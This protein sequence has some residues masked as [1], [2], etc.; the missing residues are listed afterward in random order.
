MQV[1]TFLSFSVPVSGTALD[2]MLRLIGVAAIIVAFFKGIKSLTTNPA[3]PVTQKNP[4]A[5]P[6]S[7]PPTQPQPLPQPLVDE[8]IT[9][10]IIAVIAA[11]VAY[12]V[13]SPQRIVSIK[14]QSTTWEKAGR[15]SVLSSHRI[16]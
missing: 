11:A 3:P 8:T 13:G 9:P 15:Q 14:R 2:D 16:R 1:L 10:E 7:P 4:V 12:V 6:P 5:A